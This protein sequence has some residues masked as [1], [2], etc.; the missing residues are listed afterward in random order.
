MSATAAPSLSS[1]LNWL[2]ANEQTI[3][4]HRGRVVALLFWNA[5]SGYCQNLIG[6]LALLRAR[7]PVQL[8]VLGI[9]NIVSIVGDGSDGWQPG[10]P[11]DAIMVTA[12]ASAA[13]VNLTLTDAKTAGYITAA[14]VALTGSRAATSTTI[15]SR[16]CA[17][18]AF[19]P[20]RLTIAIRPKGEPSTRQSWRPANSL[21]GLPSPSDQPP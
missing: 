19:L 1:S 13:L 16:L 12:G 2:N 4:A 15:A 21:R 3:A 11:F 20:S 9:H 14:T 6:E 5:S 17:F 10:A 8:A 7:Y 18:S